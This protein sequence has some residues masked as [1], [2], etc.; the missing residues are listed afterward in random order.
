MVKPFARLQ[1]L[2]S[3]DF[4]LHPTLCIYSVYINFTNALTMVNTDRFEG[5]H[6]LG[7]MILYSH[8]RTEPYNSFKN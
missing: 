4:D 8:H 6:K 3:P 1:S 7:I 5:L 2:L